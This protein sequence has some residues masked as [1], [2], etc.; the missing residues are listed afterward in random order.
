VW[1]ITETLRPEATAFC[2]LAVLQE[3]GRGGDGHGSGEEMKLKR[4]RNE[5]ERKRLSCSRLAKGKQPG[6]NILHY[7]HCYSAG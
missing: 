2:V 7:V 1:S 3:E 5:S 4:Q 6:E